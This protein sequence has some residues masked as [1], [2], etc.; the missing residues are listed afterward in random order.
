MLFNLAFA[1]HP[2]ASISSHEPF[3]SRISDP[4]SPM[5]LLDLSPAGFQSQ[6]FW[7]LVSPVLV[8]KAVL[9]DERYEPFAPQGVAPGFASWLWGTWWVRGLWQGCISAFPACFSE[10]S[11]LFV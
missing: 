4:Y 10:V 9:P 6:M 8:L 2:G 3:K 7:G 11:L 1:L 5:V